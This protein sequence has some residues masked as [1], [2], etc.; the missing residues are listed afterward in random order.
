MRASRPAKNEHDS[1]TSSSPLTWYST[2]PIRWPTIVIS[3]CVVGQHTH[4]IG[5]Q[6]GTL[7]PHGTL[8]PPLPD[9]T[10]AGALQADPG[11]KIS[12]RQGPPSTLIP[13]RPTPSRYTAA[14]STTRYVRLLH[15][16]TK[17]HSNHTEVAV[18][19]THCCSG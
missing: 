19:Y 12:R 14:N 5:T 9:S 4:H 13:S 6:I 18:S 16:Q 7:S 15:Q 11:Y 2:L 1:S 17:P 8:I 3:G 10:G